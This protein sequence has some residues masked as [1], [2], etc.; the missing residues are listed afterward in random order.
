METAHRVDTGRRRAKAGPK[1]W[2][3]RPRKA[4]PLRI[5]LHLAVVY[6]IPGGTHIHEHVS[7]VRSSIIHDTNTAA[8]RIVSRSAPDDKTAFA[9]LGN[10]MRVAGKGG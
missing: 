10:A 5:P 9:V 4:L 6:R 2:Q 3:Y 1:L 8:S 7:R